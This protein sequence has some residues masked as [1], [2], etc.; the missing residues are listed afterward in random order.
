MLLFLYGLLMFS[1]DH[2]GIDNSAASCIAFVILAS[3]VSIYV[4]S[5]FVVAVVMCSW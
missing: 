2:L 3:F 5:M 4:Y 1:P